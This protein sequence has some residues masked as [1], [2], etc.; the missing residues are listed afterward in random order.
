MADLW[1][2]GVVYCVW[3][4]S[5]SVLI[6]NLDA[7]FESESFTWGLLAFGVAFVNRIFSMCSGNSDSGVLLYGTGGVFSCSAFW[8]GI[9]T[10]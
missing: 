1:T 7:I 8:S 3:L 10:G 5:S 9:D 6:V 2:Y 4:F